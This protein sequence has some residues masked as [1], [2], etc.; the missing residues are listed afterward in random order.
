MFDR[1]SELSALELD[2]APQLGDVVRNLFAVMVCHRTPSGDRG[3]S[4]LRPRS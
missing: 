2:V 4:R 1:C 3:I